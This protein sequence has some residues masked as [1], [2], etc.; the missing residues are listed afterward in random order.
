MK[1]KWRTT[2]IVALLSVFFVAG[3][4]LVKPG[5]PVVENGAV[6]LASLDFSA[7]TVVLAGNWEFY[8]NRLLEPGDFQKEKPVISHELLMV[9]GSWQN[10][11]S[12]AREYPQY[13]V[14]T[15]RI[16]VEIPESL[17]DPAISVRR[18]SRAYKLYAGGELLAEVGRVSADAARYE[19]GARPMMVS[20]P[21][22]PQPL[23]II[24]QV[25]NLDYVRG[26]LREAPVFGSRALLE[27]QH[28]QALVVQVIFIGLVMA[29]FLLYF[30]FY[31]ADRKNTASLAFALLCLLTAVRGSLWGGI[32]LL[33]LFPAAPM[34]LGTFLHY[35]SGYLTLPA[36]LL[37]I[38]RLFPLDYRD[39]WFRI[40]L[41]P[42][43]LFLLLLFLPQ[44]VM[45][46][47][48][49]YFYV[50]LLLMMG[51][52]A[53]I[54]IRA[55]LQGRPYAAVM[56]FMT[57]LF[58]LTIV[59]DATNY[60]ALGGS[61]IPYMSL[62]GNVAIVIAMAVILTSR[63]KDINQEMEHLHQ[64]LLEAASLKVKIKETE[65][66]FLQAQIKP[67]FLY[68]ALN[69]IAYVSEKDGQRG[70][71]LTMDLAVY[72]RNSLEFNDMGKTVPLEKELGFVNTYFRIE[73]ARFGERIS[74]ELDIDAPGSLRVPMFVLQP[75]VENAVRH[76]IAKKTTGGKV[77]LSVKKAAE[78]VLFRVEDNGA[79]IRPEKLPGILDGTGASKGVGLVNI[80]QR[81]IS[82]YGKGLEITSL[83]G[84][85]VSVSFALGTK[86]AHGL[87]KSHG[88]AEH[89]P[90]ERGE[91][92]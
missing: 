39:K 81:L 51:Y 92:A 20:L 19:A 33:S 57:H 34:A 87:K 47:F 6:D 21:A 88:A 75:L 9:P 74:L 68:N 10:N 72:L 22:E 42:T 46:S 31:L 64:Q 4:L 37:L 30:I 23:E 79:G 56:C 7:T 86:T 77:T 13:G 53:M 18:I 15:Y 90:T 69:A 24:I 67:H 50:Y 55:V 78:E 28:Y 26:G 54:L 25:A 14:A 11:P 60:M 58:Y 62:F 61:F 32:P 89:A 35:L 66:S 27:Q 59:S 71:D 73:K 38:T 40:M 52:G 49:P 83:P 84:K 41:L 85:G 17:Q 70:S 16:I 3:Y 8:W 45:A 12:L 5:Q 44:G 65:L 63:Q 76:G 43:L 48:N 36:L 29:F 80:H 2:Y 82:L 91:Q 1:K